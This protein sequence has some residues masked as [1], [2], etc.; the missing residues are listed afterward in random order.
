MALNEDLVANNIQIAEVTSSIK[1]SSQ[2]RANDEEEPGKLPNLKVQSLIVNGN[3]PFADA[4]TTFNPELTFNGEHV[5]KQLTASQLTI[6]E[7]IINRIPLRKLLNVTRLKEIKGEKI[8]KNLKV[9]ELI[10]EETFQNIPKSFLDVNEEAVLNASRKIEFH[11]DINVKN[12]KVQFINRFNLTKLLNDTLVNDKE[13]VINGD[14]VAK[15]LVTVGSLKVEKISGNPVDNLMTVNTDQTI[16]ARVFINKFY[17]SSLN[18]TT[19]NGEKFTPASI[20]TT[21]TPIIVIPTTRF[22]N[23]SITKNLNVKDKGTIKNFVESIQENVIGTKITD[24]FQLY[25]GRV[26]I[27]GSLKL[28]DLQF[29]SMQSRL[30]IENTRVS[31]N[32]HF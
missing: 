13:V 18:A 11:G 25:N 28:Q 15:D 32:F 2:M 31:H 23:I 30:F 26:V 6:P 12:L 19:V 16:A 8:F 20:A 10:I 17:T 22:M 9:S 7:S 4:M 29:Q 3:N 1:K 21:K 27:K 14:L 5:L 24:L